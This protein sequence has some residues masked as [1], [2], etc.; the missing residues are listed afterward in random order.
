LKAIGLRKASWHGKIVDTLRVLEIIKVE[1]RGWM[2][3]II[4]EEEISR[5]RLFG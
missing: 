2:G 3:Y 4:V 1:S 5:R